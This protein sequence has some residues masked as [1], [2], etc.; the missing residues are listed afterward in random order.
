LLCGFL[1]SSRFRLTG[2]LCSRQLAGRERNQREREPS[3][4]NERNPLTSPLRGRSV[5]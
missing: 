4:S 1:F 3:V 5:F 2:W